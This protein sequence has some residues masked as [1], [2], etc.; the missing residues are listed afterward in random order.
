VI[1]ALSAATIARMPSEKVRTTRAVY[2]S[3]GLAVTKRDADRL[4]QRNLA[5]T[6]RYYGRALLLQQGRYRARLQRTIVASGA[7]A[8]AHAL[9]RRQGAILTSVHLGDFE[10]AASWI[11]EVLGSRPAVPV[12]ECRSRAWQSFYD[13]LRTSCGFRL[14]RP[15]TRLADLEA[16]LN[17]GRPVVLMLDRRPSSEG[18]SSRWFG[19]PA[20]VSAAAS[21]LSLRTGAPIFSAAT[22]QDESGHRK[23]HFGTP[24]IVRS[25]DD[26]VPLTG[27]L[28]DD[29]ETCVRAAP[30]QLHVP[31]YPT[32]L[33]WRIDIARRMG[34]AGLE[35]ATKGL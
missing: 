4:V 27:K 29:L 20:T 1:A 19:Q 34:R 26:E 33:P 30:E 23:L 13:D 18:L 16:D 17:Q 31:G 9:E 22:W 24:R 5:F 6:A 32:Q 15:G 14:R 25:Q 3:T 28:I 11:A 8:L 7:D 35:P 2:T 10:L 21:A 12:A